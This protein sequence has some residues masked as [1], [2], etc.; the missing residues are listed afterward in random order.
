MTIL[1]FC[2]KM[3]AEGAT[4]NIVAIDCPVYVDFKFAT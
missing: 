4:Y 2:E 3:Q 1:P